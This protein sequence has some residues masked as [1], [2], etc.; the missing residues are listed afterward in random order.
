MCMWRRIEEADTPSKNDRHHFKRV[1]VC[2][3]GAVEYHGLRAGRCVRLFRIHYPTERNI[4]FYV[5]FPARRDATNNIPAGYSILATFR[6]RV[7]F[8]S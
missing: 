5:L 7:T 2:A 8:V 3:L 1:L 6:A 4:S